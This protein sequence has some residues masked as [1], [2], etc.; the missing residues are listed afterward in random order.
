MSDATLRRQ[1]DK[2]MENLEF[3][4]KGMRKDIGD[5]KTKINNGF[6]NSI[7]NTENKVNYIDER[8]REEHKAIMGKIDK[9]IFLW[10][11]GSITIFIG[12]VWMVVKEII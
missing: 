7:K 8:N 12:A 4:V 2:R 9:I 5:I 11:S 1:D 3:E 10:I 6:D